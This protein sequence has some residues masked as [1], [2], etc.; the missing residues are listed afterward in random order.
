MKIKKNKLRNLTE[1]DIIN[2]LKKSLKE[3]T[4]EAGKKGKSGLYGTMDTLEG[5]VASLEEEI[6]ALKYAIIDANESGEDRY[7]IKVNMA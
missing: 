3:Q 7:N 1:S 2:G 4:I 5:R 6:M